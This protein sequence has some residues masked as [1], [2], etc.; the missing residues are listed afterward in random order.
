MQSRSQLWRCGPATI[1]DE[2]LF[3]ILIGGDRRTSPSL[4]SDLLTQIGGIANLAR[5]SPNELVKVPGLGRDRAARIVAAF[6]LGRR[7]LDHENTDE[8]LA[9]PEDVHRF[10]RSRLANLNQELFLVIAL[11]ARHRLLE[12]TEIARG[13][14]SAVEVQPREVFRPLIRIA[15]ASCVFVHNHPSGDPT[16]SIDDIELTSRLTQIGAMLGIRILDHVVIAGP[17]WMSV[18]QWRETRAPSLPS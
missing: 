4:A 2:T 6:E 17:K 8:E 3:Q 9:S 14:L 11:D 7:A 10:V 13:Q 18:D 5:A 15:A 12:L 16:P 1:P